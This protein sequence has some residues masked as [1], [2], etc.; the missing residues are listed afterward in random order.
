VALTITTRHVADSRYGC[1]PW[2][3]GAFRWVQVLPGEPE[4]M[5]RIGDSASVQA[6]TRVNAEQG[7]KDDAQAD[8][9]TLSGKA[10]TAGLPS[11][12]IRPAAAPGSWRQ[13]VHRKAYATR[14]RRRET[15]G[16]GPYLAWVGSNRCCPSR[17]GAWHRLVFCARAS[18]G[19]PL[20]PA[21]DRKGFRLDERLGRVRTAIPFVIGAIG[22]VHWGMAFEQQPL[23]QMA[24]DD[25]P[26]SH[27]RPGSTAGRPFSP[28]SGM[29]AK[30][31]NS[32]PLLP[33]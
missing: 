4:C 27:N 12:I 26:A 10:D 7:E 23:A 22:M 21:P 19:P 29:E 6:V 31:A 30:L 5:S 32:L 2:K 20:L 1:A 24:R 15:C 3:G 11:E 25:S 18:V 14:C 33:S 28:L 9:M 8:P 13:H 17:L 16:V